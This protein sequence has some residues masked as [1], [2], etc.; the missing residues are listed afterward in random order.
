MSS[1]FFRLGN[2]VDSTLRPFVQSKLAG[3]GIDE[4]AKAAR[5]EKPTVDTPVGAVTQWG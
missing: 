5:V 1:A 2:R 3:S 4:A